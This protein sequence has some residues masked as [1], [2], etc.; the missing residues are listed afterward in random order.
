MAD[1]HFHTDRL[2]IIGSGLLGTSVTMGLKARGFTGSITALCRTRA[3]ADKALATG[4]YDRATLDPASA[5]SEATLAV[6]AVPLS[7][8]G[9]VFAQIA[10]HGPADLIITDVGSAKAS[11]ISDAR[12]HLTDLSRV[13]GAHP[14]AGS[15]K[16]GPDAGDADL[17]VG[18]PC[19]LTLGDSDDPDAVAAVRSLWET[20]GMSVLVMSPQEHDEKVAVVSHLPHLAALMLVETAEQLG[21]LELASTGYRDT[22][23]LASSNPPMRADILMANRESVDQA[24]EVFGARI[25]EARSVLQAGDPQAILDMLTRARDS[26]ERWLDQQRNSM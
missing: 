1:E 16:S 24:L 6:I 4:A 14:M 5:L 25:A 8:F 10:E 20:L 12:A 2:V 23:R 18:K 7:G 11:V 3:S 13:I 15:E 26:R 22:T 21:G 17:F 9:A 19:I